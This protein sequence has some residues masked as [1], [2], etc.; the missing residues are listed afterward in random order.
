MTRSGVRVI[1]GVEFQA[2]Q[3]YLGQIGFL[4]ASRAWP[5]SAAWSKEVIRSV[6][7]VERAGTSR[8]PAGER[9]KIT[10]D[11]KAEKLKQLFDDC[12][13]MPILGRMA[14]DV[15]F[16]NGKR[17]WY[18]IHGMHAMF[19]YALGIAVSTGRTWSRAEAPT[20]DQIQYAY[21]LV[22][23]VFLLDWFLII[24]SRER[25]LPEHIGNAQTVLRLEGLLNRCQGYD[26]HL[27]L[28][29]RKTFEKID[30]DVVRTLGWSPSL[31]PEVSR[32]VHDVQQ[33]RMDAFQ[34]VAQERLSSAKAAGR[35]QYSDMVTKIYSDQSRL[36][37]DLFVVRPPELATNLGLPE[38][39]L[40]AALKDLSISPGCQPD[41]RLPMQD[42]LARFYSAVD[43]GDDRYF[44]GLLGS[45]LQEAHIWFYDL[46]Q[47][48]GLESLRRKYL[49]ARDKAAEELTIS[50]VGRVFGIDRTFGSVEYAA[51]GRPDVDCIAVV[52]H[53]VLILECKAHSLTP[54]GRRGAPDRLSRKVDELV[55]K[56][57]IQAAR[58]AD[59]LSRGR[60]VFGRFQKERPLVVD[61]ASVLPR[62][63]VTYEQVD[64]LA[65]YR[66]ESG[67]PASRERAWVV[68]LADLLVIADL[69]ESPSSF[70]YYAVS[71]WQQ[72]N[73]TS[74]VVHAE[75][76][77][78]GIFLENNAFF[79][80]LIKEG[81][82]DIGVAVGPSAHE[83]NDYYTTPPEVEAEVR[84]PHVLVP[85]QVI[86][87]LD[88]AFHAD[89]PRWKDL[90][91]AVFA[92]P[93][94]TW[95][96]LRNV[97]RKVERNGT[98]RRVKLVTANPTLD[99]WIDHRPEATGFSA[100]MDRE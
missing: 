22:A 61:A 9:A 28:I 100:S 25:S 50:A 6:R 74:L 40:R 67:A 38:E 13:P 41:F 94:K 69:L 42:N 77:M 45:L 93:E 7:E 48:R 43:L 66:S 47:R 17:D 96:R 59:H 30:V 24:A 86:D 8:G 84:K 15:V 12:D 56:P 87:M 83:I 79:S 16:G 64:P 71:R 2:E 57:S 80:D 82:S 21:D 4:V 14:N 60:T 51:N 76:D 54:A 58:F 91:T 44:I 98:P 68:S 35:R 11:A 23:E 75:G 55:V 53:D 19:Q 39:T 88:D 90:V 62:V 1:D 70:W 46:I 5:A 32:A 72:C 33:R 63:V 89:D 34:P 3:H 65:A 73:E 37:Q 29:S 99:L 20:P 85:P 52:P 27:S 26:Q 36:L 18:A 78:L 81:R 49:K 10:R 92:E 31:I 97:L 95:T